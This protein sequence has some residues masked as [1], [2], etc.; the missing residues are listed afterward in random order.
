MGVHC[1]GKNWDADATG[2]R[3]HPPEDEES[4]MDDLLACLGEEQLRVERLSQKLESLGV[5]PQDLIR[6]IGV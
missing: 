4:A 1:R 6:E 5:D 3:E 2:P